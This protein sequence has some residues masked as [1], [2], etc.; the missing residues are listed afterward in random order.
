MR[1]KKIITERSINESDVT[2]AR[3]KTNTV[4]KSVPL[5]RVLWVMVA[6]CITAAILSFI[7]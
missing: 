1:A 2:I 5:V 7:F 4:R 3:R 6:V